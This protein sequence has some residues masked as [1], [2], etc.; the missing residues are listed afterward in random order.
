MASVFTALLPSSGESFLLET[1]H[2]GE[3]RVVLVDAGRAK[4]SGANSLQR[5]IETKRFGNIVKH[6]DIAICTHADNDHAGGFPNFIKSWCGKSGKTIGEFWLPAAWAIVDDCLHG[7]LPNLLECLKSGAKR[8]AEVCFSGG[9]YPQEMVLRRD[10]TL[11]NNVRTTINQYL[12]DVVNPDTPIPQKENGKFA[13]GYPNDSIIASILYKE[14]ERTVDMIAQI[15][16][17][18]HDHGITIR[19][20]D[21]TP[22][23]NCGCAGGGEPGFLIPRNS[24]EGKPRYRRNNA[25]MFAMLYLTRANIESLVFQ[26]VEDAHDP[27]V[28]FLADS[29]LAI[30]AGKKKTAFCDHSRTGPD[31]KMKGPCIYT[32]PHHGSHNNDYAYKALKSWLGRDVFEQS[33][34]IK[35]GGVW[36]QKAGKFQH[37]CRRVCARRHERFC[38]RKLPKQQRTQAVQIKSSGRR[39][40]CPPQQGCSCQGYPCRP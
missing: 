8:S 2:N 25:L 4:K 22:F 29:E 6:I 10:G 1:E 14:T 16:K 26:R 36:N 39:W 37:V 18:A 5:A 17:S 3:P 31:P 11:V 21:F 35:N 7:E 33:I 38:G 24:V 19:W 15:I 40:V 13:D 34:A 28:L 20:F 23:K 27:S 32:A 9:E 12:E 30:R